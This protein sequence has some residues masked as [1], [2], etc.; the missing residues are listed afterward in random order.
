MCDNVVYLI[1]EYGI[2]A[3]ARTG[4]GIADNTFKD[5]FFRSRGSRIA[6]WVQFVTLRLMMVVASLVP[7]LPY[8][9]QSRLGHKHGRLGCDAHG[10]FKVAD[11]VRTIW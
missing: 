4:R 3:Q 10:I 9:R 11:T 6:L 7:A 5:E 2:R 8:A 1:L